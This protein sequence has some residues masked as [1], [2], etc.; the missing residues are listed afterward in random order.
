METVLRKCF[1]AICITLLPALICGQE[2]AQTPP[3]GW[4]SYD[5]YGA[6]VLEHEV[7]GNADV[8][9]ALLKKHGW[10]YVV[11][12]YCWSY[13]VISALNNPPQDEDFEPSLP[14][15]EYGRLL[16]AVVKFPSA[17][18]GKGF[19]PLADY[20]HGLG[21]KFGIHVMRGIP[22][23]AVAKKL[24]IKGTRYTA[25]QIADKTST[26]GWLNQMYG[27]DMGKPGAQEY[28]NS[29]WEL[30]ASWDVDY[31][32]VDD[33]LSPFWED[34]I[35]AVNKAISNSGRPMVL[36]LS[37][38]SETPIEKA[39][40]LK[41]NS[42]LW[43]ISADF[44]DVWEDIE[45]MFELT[46]KW[47]KHIGPGHW[48]DADMIP[49]G[50]LSRRGPKGP[51]RESRFTTDEKYTLMTLW[52]IARS[53]LMYGG[54]LMQLRTY[55]LPF[56]TNDEVLMV[57]RSSKNNQQLFRRGNFV[58]WVADVSGS[59]DK[60]LAVFNLGEDTKTPIHVALSDLDFSGKVAIRDL[61]KKEEL[62]IFS[63]EFVPLISS[64]GAGLYRISAD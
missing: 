55:D 59:K 34:E 24:P 26:C 29:L 33:I 54:D 36:S 32:K 30:Y 62:G 16:P 25:D 51:E 44:W 35:I 28:Y 3:M 12:D 19:K 31:V 56:L 9:A 46:H 21:L 4:N 11:V 10:E 53:P 23:E 58:A 47:E 13:P 5:S 6:A 18:D 38:G 37:H 41:E 7:K 15:D 42:H 1:I 57:G 43:R 22:R 8:M 39:D 40:F 63:K 48:P 20:V 52:N 64:H 61:W 2:L 17:A 27:V 50:R 60:Y 45:G 14:M 49:F